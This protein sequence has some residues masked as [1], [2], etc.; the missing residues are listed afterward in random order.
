MLS[1][2]VSFFLY[3]VDVIKSGPFSTRIILPD[4]SLVLYSHLFDPYSSELLTDADPLL[5]ASLTSGSKVTT[6]HFFP[7]DSTLNP[8]EFIR[9]TA[10]FNDAMDFATSACCGHAY[11]AVLKAVKN[12]N[13]FIFFM[14]LVPPVVCFRSS[15]FHLRQLKNNCNKLTNYYFLYAAKIFNYFLTYYY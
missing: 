6:L 1:F 2:A 9:S 11:A 4:E 10:E 13:K 15:L 12:S 14:V 3:L 8:D 5:R 7:S